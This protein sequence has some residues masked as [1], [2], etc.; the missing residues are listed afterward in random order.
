MKTTA[1]IIAIVVIALCFVITIVIEKKDTD[2]RKLS[3]IAVMTA[4]SVAG[5]F[6]FA[7][8]PGFKPVTAIVIITGMCLG[9]QAGFLCGSLTAL[10]SNFYFGQGPWTPFQMLVWGIIGILA[11]LF[12]NVLTKNKLVLGAF[13]VLS[14]V[15]F[16][17]LMDIY[18]VIW[19]YGGFSI[20]AYGLAVSSALYFTVEYAVSNV[21]FLL[22]LAGPVSR[23][24]DRARRRTEIIVK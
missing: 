15:I 9:I 16:S 14:G 5:R 23:K 4:M 8:F 20:A 6:I 11:A 1:L 3:L 13:G 24:L 19:A 2:V 10:V 7:A 12:A 22:C 21:I 18:T 17:L